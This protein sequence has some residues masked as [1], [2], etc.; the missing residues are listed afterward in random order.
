MPAAISQKA[1][2]R[3]AA[4]HMT[5]RRPTDR[6]STPLIPIYSEFLCAEPLE[7][8]LGSGIETGTHPRLLEQQ[9]MIRLMSLFS[10]I[11]FAGLWNP[12]L[13][14]RKLEDRVKN[15]KEVIPVRS[16]DKPVLGSGNCY[17]GRID[18][19]SA[20]GPVGA[21]ADWVVLETPEEIHA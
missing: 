14:G 2:V 10:D 1:A 12:D 7:I 21:T 11:F 9:Q 18:W 20:T 6:G 15:A 19:G 4:Q 5:V 13:G 17:Q 3:S 16:Q 8:P